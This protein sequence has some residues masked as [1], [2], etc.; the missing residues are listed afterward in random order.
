ML[1]KYSI[2]FPRFTLELLLFSKNKP[3]LHLCR[4][5]PPCICSSCWNPRRFVLGPPSTNPCSGHVQQRPKG[6]QEGWPSSS[7]E[8][9]AERELVRKC[10]VGVIGT[11]VTEHLKM[12]TLGHVYHYT[13]HG[14]PHMIIPNDPPPPPYPRAKSYSPGGVPSSGRNPTHPPAHLRPGKVKGPP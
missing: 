6:P 12:Y 11:K 9:T 3:K 10:A 1:R 14:R 7:T 4:S 8:R 13:V 2:F 5:S